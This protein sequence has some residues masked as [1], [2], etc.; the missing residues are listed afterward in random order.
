MLLE[1]RRLT[2]YFKLT[3]YFYD[4]YIFVFYKRKMATFTNLEY[5]LIMGVFWPTRLLKWFELTNLQT[6]LHSNY[7]KINKNIK[8]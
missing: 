3:S 6:S 7:R 1:K 2:N 5:F 4:I 8:T